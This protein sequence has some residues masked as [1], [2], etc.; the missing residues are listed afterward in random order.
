MLDVDHFKRFNDTYGHEEGDALLRELGA[1]L[2]AGIRQ[3][4]VA[5]RYGGEEFLIMLPDAPLRNAVER[6]EMLRRRIRTS[7]KI[8]QEFVTVSI[9]VAVYPDHGLTGETVVGAADQALYQAKDAGRDRVVVSS[10][11]A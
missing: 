11:G 8:K 3:E 10:I 5:C 4:D 7:L 1:V 9:G 6:A 2:Q